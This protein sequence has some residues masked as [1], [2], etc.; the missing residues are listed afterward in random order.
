MSPGP[1]LAFTACAET[2][3]RFISGATQSLQIAVCWFTHPEIY[4]ALLNQAKAGLDVQLIVNFDQINFR[5]DGLNFSALEKAGAKIYGFPGPGLLHHKFAVADEKRVLTGSFNWSR[6]EHFDHVVVWDCSQTSMVFAQA[7]GDLIP[8][9]KLLNLLA[10]KPIRHISFQQ[11]HQPTLWSVQDLRKAIIAG[12]KVWIA[13]FPTRE[14]PVWQQCYTGQRHYCR[15]PPSIAQYWQRRELWEP[16]AF[17]AWLSKQEDQA[18]LKATARYCLKVRSGDV[19]IAV[20]PK[21]RLLALGLVSSDPETS[22]LPTYGVS[23]YVPWI[24]WP[25]GVTVPDPAL[26]KPGRTLRRYS[27]SGLQ[28]VEALNAITLHPNPA[29]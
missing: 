6:S 2:V 12:G 28:V 13:P 25:D 22:P 18:G 27:G 8:E 19:L 24:K 20:E 5:Q 16:D 1:E 4:N 21:K 3:I 17:C 9:C 23:R 15:A 10:A 7:F 29:F 26:L 14:M 11:L